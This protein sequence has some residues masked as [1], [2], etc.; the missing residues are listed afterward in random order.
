MSPLIYIILAL[1]LLNNI[2][3]SGSSISNFFTNIRVLNKK[4]QERINEFINI[5]IEE[6]EYE[7][8]KHKRT[9]KRT[10]ERF[11]GEKVESRIRL[12]EVKNQ[13]KFLK[14]LLK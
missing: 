2:L 13:V 12:D 7:S 14:S 3:I 10:Y 1:V 9:Q 4:D 6:L 5:K 8:Q 11:L